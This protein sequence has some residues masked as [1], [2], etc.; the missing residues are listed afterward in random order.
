MERR[1]LTCLRARYVYAVI[2]RSRAIIGERGAPS[3]LCPRY[4]CAK[5][6]IDEPI[7]DQ[8]IR[9]KVDSSLGSL[10]AMSNLVLSNSWFHPGLHIDFVLFLFLEC[11]SDHSILTINTIT[12]EIPIIPSIKINVSM[13][14]IFE[15][16]P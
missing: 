1:A 5:V 6:S 9:A 15:S 16:E 13:L 4:L 10:Y 12:S 3:S 2:V 11:F 14:H 7:N 8:M